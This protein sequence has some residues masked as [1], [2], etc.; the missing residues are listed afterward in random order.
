MPKLTPA[1][2]A[3]LDLA[4]RDTIYD[5]VVRILSE[6]GNHGLTMNRVAATAGLA[7]GSLYNYFRD[8]RR[9]LHFVYERAYEPIRTRLDETA[10]RNGTASEKLEAIARMYFEYVDTHRKLFDFL[11]NDAAVR[12]NLKNEQD[13]LRAH[14]IVELTAIIEKGVETGEFRPTKPEHVAELLLGAVRQ[15]AERQLASGRREP[16]NESVDMLC[17]VFLN[18]LATGESRRCE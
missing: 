3:A 14:A 6:D 2:K 7:K 12:G 4:V 8:K 15:M 10:R 17:Q 1:R 11:L 16:V 9:L 13:S 5:A 18:G